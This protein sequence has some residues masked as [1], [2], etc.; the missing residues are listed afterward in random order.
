[1]RS[2]ARFALAAVVVA[3]SAAAQCPGSPPASFV[4]NTSITGC[5]LNL[6]TATDPSA[7]SLF[8]PS[9]Q[10]NQASVT[11]GEFMVTT[12]SSVQGAPGAPVSIVYSAATPTP[13]A[14]LPFGNLHLNLGAGI[15]ALVD[16]AGIFTGI[17]N[18]FLG[19][20]GPSAL[21]SL[22]LTASPLPGIAQSCWTMQ[23]LT[24]DP[25]S[26]FGFRMSNAVSL[27]VRGQVASLTP[28]FGPETASVVVN[29][30]GA[31]G[32]GTANFTTFQPA[33]GFLPPTLAT[34]SGSTAFSVPVAAGSGPVTYE[35]ASNPGSPTASDPDDINTWFAVVDSFGVVTNPGPTTLTLNTS[36]LNPNEKAATVTNILPN[37]GTVHTYLAALQAGDVVVVEA[38]S[39][40]VA[41]TALLDGYGST[42]NPGATEGADL[43]L[44]F[45][46]VT[47]GLPLTYDQGLAGP[48]AIHGDDDSGPGFNPR[49]TF[50]V[51]TTDNYQILVGASP[52][53]VAAFVTGDYMLNVRVLSGA[54]SVTRFE[55]PTA[56]NQINARAAGQQVKVIGAN[57][58]PAGQTVNVTL[59]PMHGLY[60]PVVVSNVV[61]TSATQLTFTLPA[62]AAPTFCV[63][64]HLVQITSNT[65]NATSFLWDNSFFAPL[66]VRP[67]LLVVR[68]AGL[69][70]LSAAGGPITAA[71]PNTVTYGVQATTTN[72]QSMP[73]GQFFQFGANGAQTIYIEALAT[74]Y[75][76]T[77]AADFLS[78][79]DTRTE[80]GAT[81]GCYE[82][83][84]TLFAPGFIPVLAYNADDGIVPTA[85]PWPFVATPCIGLNSAMLVPGALGAGAATATFL[86]SVQ[87]QIV[88]APLGNGKGFIVNFVVL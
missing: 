47:N 72:P 6:L 45:T 76:L 85:Y 5:E 55:L 50:Q 20:P 62:L 12:L 17:P 32:V 43:L 40:N 29:A 3:T 26:P 80:T 58:P 35:Y 83:Q 78:L 28:Q 25:S 70:I 39:M 15:G 1:M 81:A 88:T 68:S 75:A 10:D 73:A 65:N 48:F 9:A 21:F 87:A 51:R 36:P 57:F 86:A 84:L 56:V 79:V 63:G 54:P 30:I 42:F 44:N 71:T 61:T 52:A 49:F 41:Q 27:H 14:P 16:G 66:G 31:A 38:Y 59:T 23:A 7:N 8:T 82:P 74:K 77:T 64:S 18:P 4:N 69:T 53:N 24:L 46:Q 37:S 13:A 33:G 2:Y 11:V 19:H 34:T 60:A 22:G 67:E